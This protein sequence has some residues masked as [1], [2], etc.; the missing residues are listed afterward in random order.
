[1]ALSLDRSYLTALLNWGNVIV[2]KQQLAEALRIYHEGEEALAA[3]GAEGASLLPLFLMNLSRCYYEMEEDERFP[4][5][6]REGH[7]RR[8]CSRG[9]IRVPEDRRGRGT[10][11]GRGAEGGPP[12]RRGGGVS[13]G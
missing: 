6:L 13:H 11:G 4:A 8:S 9:T 3:A 10:A 5:V 1:M 7:C 12:V 2:L